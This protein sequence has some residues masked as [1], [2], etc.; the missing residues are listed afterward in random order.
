MHFPHDWASLSAALVV[1]AY[2]NRLDRAFRNYWYEHDLLMAD[3]CERKQI[4]LSS[5][6]SRSR[7]RL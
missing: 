7:R 5:L 3:Y 6:P 1:L 2:L 4:K